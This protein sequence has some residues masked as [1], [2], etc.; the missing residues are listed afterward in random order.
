MSKQVVG[1]VV[2]KVAAQS[3]FMG[4]LPT[5]MAATSDTAIAGSF[6]GP[7]VYAFSVTVV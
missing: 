2:G 5:V 4:S 6:V 7:K 3:A 1:D